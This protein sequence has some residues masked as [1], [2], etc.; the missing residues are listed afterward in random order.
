MCNSGVKGEGVRPTSK[1][2]YVWGW[3]GK[4]SKAGQGD[5]LPLLDRLFILLHPHTKCA[6][7][8]AE[9][10]KKGELAHVHTFFYGLFL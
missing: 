8:A 9:K 5:Q 10:K 6:R 2:V 4:V 7:G 3:E 1:N